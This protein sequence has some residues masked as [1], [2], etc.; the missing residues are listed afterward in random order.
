MA[1][2][3]VIDIVDENLPE[4]DDQSEW[5]W[6]ALAKTVNTRWKL[7]VRDR[8]LKRQER[9]QISEMLISEARQGIEKIDLAEGAKF[10]DEDFGVR[11]A[12]AWVQYKFGIHLDHAE[13]KDLDAT[14]FIGL[15]RAKA[16]LAY[17]E[18][19]AA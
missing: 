11:T 17:D 14:R 4:G 15:V 6:E 7:N 19:E 16:A 10:L 3:Q 2:S 12:I 8:D 5:N 1:E 13:V 9:E 18:K